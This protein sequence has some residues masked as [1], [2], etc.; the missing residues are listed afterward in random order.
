MDALGKD[1]HTSENYSCQLTISR[2][3]AVRDE[4]VPL[5]S[6]RIKF[7]EQLTNLSRKLEQRSEEEAVIREMEYVRSSR[8]E[9]IAISTTQINDSFYEID[10][11]FWKSF[12][13]PM[14][15]YSSSIFPSD[16]ASLADAEIFTLDD[17]ITK[18]GIK[19][20]WHILD[21]G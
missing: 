11:A 7:R 21:L 5:S 19:D 1:T 16:S 12:L 3:R 15:K 20:G 9:P 4:G 8:T 17:Y 14:M 18:A 10:L 13:G 2:L 6:L